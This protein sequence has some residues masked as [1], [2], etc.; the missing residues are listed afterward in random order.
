MKGETVKVTVR[1]L[2]LAAWVRRVVLGRALPPSPTPR[3][4]SAPESDTEGLTTPSIVM[5]MVNDARRQ[6]RT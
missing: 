4:L 6:S 3:L 5:K 1:A 2:D